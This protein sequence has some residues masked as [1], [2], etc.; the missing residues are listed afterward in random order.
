M[1]FFVF[2][3]C[4]RV[5]WRSAFLALMLLLAANTPLI[6]GTFEDAEAAFGK[7]DYATALRLFRSLANNGN[8]IAQDRLGN[9]YA[10]GKGVP[11]DQAEAEKWYRL[12]AEQGLAK[13]QGDLGFMYYL[14]AT[15]RTGDYTEAAKWYRLAA[16]QGDSSWPSR[17]WEPV[18]RW[19]GRAAKLR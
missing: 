6:A 7:K 11:F 19:S 5:S 17:S 13:A 14:S 1:R 18:S 4:R 16:N 15:L 10:S 12:A 9:M 2:E 8:A 3:D